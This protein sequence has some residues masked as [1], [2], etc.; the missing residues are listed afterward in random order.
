MLIFIVGQRSGAALAAGTAAAAT[1]AAT[2]SCCFIVITADT[3][4]LNLYTWNLPPHPRIIILWWLFPGD[5]HRR[6]SVRQ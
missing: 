1:A 3:E 2:G 5:N 6:Y 4:A